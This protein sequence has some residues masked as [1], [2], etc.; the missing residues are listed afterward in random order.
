MAERQLVIF[1]QE[2]DR[3]EITC[4]CGTALV[5]SALQTAPKLA[6]ECPGCGKS[7]HS[8]ATAV[9]AFREFFAAAKQHTEGGE[10]KTEEARR[11]EFR[12]REG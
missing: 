5:I 12:L 9:S 7:L 1:F 6:A 3:L 8:A 10:G 11:I 2:L 4:D